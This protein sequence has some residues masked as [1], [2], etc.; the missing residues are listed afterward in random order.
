MHNRKNPLLHCDLKPQNILINNA[1]KAEV[2]ICDFGLMF[3]L[4]SKN[5]YQCNK[6]YGTI[7]YF[8]PEKIDAKSYD[9][10]SDIWAIGVT[11]IEIINQKLINVKDT[12]AWHM[13]I[14]NEG[15]HKHTHTH[16]D[17]LDFMHALKYCPRKHTRNIRYLT[18][19][20]LV[21]IHKN[22]HVT[23]CFS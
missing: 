20:N 5:K 9:T 8:S 22:I 1:G 15:T 11:F 18:Y 12:T 2:K 14:L 17:T 10:K 7:K 16:T 3:E 13:Q 6:K 4:N 21:C 19:V 23:Q